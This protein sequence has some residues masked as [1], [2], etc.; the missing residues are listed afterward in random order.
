MFEPSLGKPLVDAIDK[1]VNPVPERGTSTLFFDGWWGYVQKDL[2]RVT[3]RRVAGW[4]TTA[5]CGGGRLVACRKVLAST[6]K[7][8]VA[9]AAG[10]QELATCPQTKPPSCSQMVPITGG[11]VGVNPFPFHNR[12]TFH[13]L[14]EVGGPAG[15]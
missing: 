9:A 13:Q 10:K 12:G 3:G 1:K 14:V 7:A 2:R 11:A 4:P 15:L 8:A 5:F 6:L